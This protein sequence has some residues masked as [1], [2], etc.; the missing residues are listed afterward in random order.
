MDKRIEKAIESVSPARAVAIL[1]NYANSLEDHARA[2]AH[3]HKAGVEWADYAELCALG[4]LEANKPIIKAIRVVVETDND[5]ENPAE[6][7]GWKVASFNRRHIAY[8]DPDRWFEGGEPIDGAAFDEGRAFKLAYYEHGLCQWSLS[9]EGPRCRFDTVDCAGVLYYDGADDGLPDGYEAREKAA[10]AFLVVYT[11]WCNGAGLGY[12]IELID[13]MG[14]AKEAD[15]CWGFY[16]S[17]AD[18]MCGEIA[19]AVLALLKEHPGATVEYGGELG[20]DYR[21]KIG[22]AMM[23]TKCAELP[24]DV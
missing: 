19:S 18:H 11:D 5:I 22:D 4:A 14:D 1:T 10:R 20:S 16:D 24:S 15:S 9:G 7:G 2:F 6:Y 3:A 17:D 21:H 13:D 23:A 8:Q 12:R